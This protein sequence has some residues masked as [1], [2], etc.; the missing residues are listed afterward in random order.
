MNKNHPKQPAWPFKNEPTRTIKTLES[1]RWTQMNK[2]E[3]GHRN[4]SSDAGAAQVSRAWW[5]ADSARHRLELLIKHRGGIDPRHRRGAQRRQIR[6]AVYGFTYSPPACSRMDFV[7][8]LRAPP[9]LWLIAPVRPAEETDVRERCIY[10]IW[11]RG[12][13]TTGG[14]CPRPIPPGS[15]DQL[16]AG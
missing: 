12:R 2:D 14:R 11:K 8:K 13:A 9:R 4:D 10:C 16:G 6:P 5:M 3:G 15:P 1:C 7:A